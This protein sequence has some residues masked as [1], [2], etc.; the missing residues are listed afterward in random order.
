MSGKEIKERCFFDD[1][2]LKDV[3]ND[4]KNLWLKNTD[5][6]HTNFYYSLLRIAFTGLKTYDMKT[7]IA[8]SA[9]LNLI[10]F[11]ISFLAF[12]FLAMLLFGRNKA[13]SYAA[14][15]LA[16]ISSGTISNTIFIRP[17][18]LQE[19]FFIIFAF[20][21]FRFLHNPRLLFKSGNIF[22]DVKF[23]FAASLILALTLLTH[24][25]SI[26]FVTL[27]LIYFI[28]CNYK[29]HLG[30]NLIVYFGIIL[31]SLIFLKLFYLQYF[32]GFSSYRGKEM[33]AA[34]G[35]ANFLSN[36]GFVFNK[37]C[38]ILH[39]YYFSTSVIIVLLSIISVYFLKLGTK[40]IVSP[41]QMAVSLCAFL[42]LGVLL[43][44][45]YKTV[46]YIM[47]VFPLFSIIIAAF[48]V[49]IQNK[50]IFYA[51]I[52]AICLA[53]SLNSVNADKID[54]LFKGKA[55]KF[56]FLK[57][58]QIPVVIILE[59]TWK[60]EEIIPHFLD[61]QKYFFTHNIDNIPQKY[62]EFYVLV[63]RA[64]EEKVD[65]S[66]YRTQELTNSWYYTQ[67]KVYVQKGIVKM[68]KQPAH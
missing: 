36:I 33:I 66:K 3:L 61:E 54:A 64:I 14:C 7:I 2:T 29:L 65:L 67:E 62:S 22:K 48:I 34:A 12:Y 56:E 52:A 10:L 37:T 19:T 27:L 17:Y 57:E 24:Y 68:D 6:P 44:A 1:D 41:N 35:N 40:I 60:A 25:Y 21:V 53:F 43:Y 26:I 59:K 28:C 45:P 30:R 16:F 13:L 31:L 58:A 47:S 63:E 18:Q 38:E 8:R 51:G 49:N 32:Q 20:C 46:R 11:S 5:S 39:E 23:C 42:F 50:K 9:I 55:A 4:I 15:F